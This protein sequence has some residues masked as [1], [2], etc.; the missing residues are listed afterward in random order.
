[1]SSAKWHS[2]FLID[3]YLKNCLEGFSLIKFWIEAADIQV[4]ALQ[5][6][7]ALS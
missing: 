4:V 3:D 2:S 1:M 6:G 5:R 7:N